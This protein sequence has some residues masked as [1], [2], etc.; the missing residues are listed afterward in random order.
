MAG[1]DERH[2]RLTTAV[3]YIEKLVIRDVGCDVN[4]GAGAPSGGNKATTR[5]AAYSDP[6][7]RP[8]EIAHVSRSIALER[9]A[10][11]LEE[12]PTV[13]RLRER[14]DRAETG[15]RMLLL[16]RIHIG[17]NFLRPIPPHHAA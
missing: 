8:A 5:A 1:I 6:L 15:P 13:Y 14:A 12:V 4:V 3:Q 16:D 7:D 17:G 10:E 9:S 11:I 2:A